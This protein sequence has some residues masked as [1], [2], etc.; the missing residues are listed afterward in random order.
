MGKGYSV[1]FRAGRSLKISA[2]TLP[3]QPTIVVL[4]GL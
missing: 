2:R 4:D 1:D 3:S